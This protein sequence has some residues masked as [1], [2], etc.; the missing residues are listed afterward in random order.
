M[1]YPC[2]FRS[3]SSNPFRIYCAYINDT[4][5]ISAETDADVIRIR[6]YAPHSNFSGVYELSY[7]LFS[8]CNTHSRKEDTKHMIF[9]FGPNIPQSDV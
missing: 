1:L 2:K 6:V 7:S 5:K 8:I 4:N 3:K 9:D